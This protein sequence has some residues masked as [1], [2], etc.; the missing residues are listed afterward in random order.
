MTA[1]K[2]IMIFTLLSPFLASPSL[3]AGVNAPGMTNLRDDSSS[4]DMEVS[5]FHERRKERL[6]SLI[7]AMS[8]EVA[9]LPKLFK[10]H[11]KRQQWLRIIMS[12]PLKNKKHKSLYI[13]SSSDLMGQN[14]F[15]YLYENPSLIEEVDLAYLRS[16]IG[17][18]ELMESR[19]AEH[20]GKTETK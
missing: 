10:T 6:R 8:K 9:S 3:V 7:K 14:D 13:E 16:A 15:L 4:D 19:Y 2:Y 17:F 12:L 18:Q 1:I 20:N 11:S 5:S